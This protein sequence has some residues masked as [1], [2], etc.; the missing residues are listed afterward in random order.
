M[1]TVE[2][3]GI[4]TR[5]ALGERDSAASRQERYTVRSSSGTFVGSNSGAETLK[6]TSIRRAAG[7]NASRRRPVRIKRR[8]KG[9]LVELESANSKTK[10]ARVAFIEN[11]QMVL[12]DLPGDQI[13]NA[14]ITVPNQPFEMDEVETEDE[15]G[16][17]IWGYRFKALAEPSDA[18]IQTLP[19]DDER[20]RK[21]DL[22]LRTFGKTQD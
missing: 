21:R 13:R 1:S 6:F 8:I 19:L 2:Y 14:G 5:T 9:F 4:E 15:T 22:I 10:E 17:I 18:Y 3:E 16:A 11:G 20:K 7:A 12:Y